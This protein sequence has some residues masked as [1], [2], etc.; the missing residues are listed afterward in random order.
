[1]PLFRPRTRVEILRDMIA[2]VVARSTLVGLR[3]NSVIFHLLAAAA[4]EDAEQYFQ[5]ANLRKLFSIYNATGSDLDERATEITPNTISRR[6]AQFASG[7][8]IFYRNGTVG[9]LTIPAGTLVAAEDAQG[10]IRFRTTATASITPG[11]D[12]VGGVGVVAVEAGARGSVA[13]NQIRQLVSRVVGLTGV[14]NPNRFDNGADR[15]SDAEFV[16]RLQLHVQSLSRGTVA[17]IRSFALNA[18]LND[19]RRALFAQVIEPAVP[20]CRFDVVI[21]DGTGTA[22]EYEAVFLG[23]DDVILNPA[24][25]GEVQV[26]TTNRPI[27]DDGSFL[28]KINGVTQTRGVDYELNA[29]RGIVELTAPLAPGDD[30]RARYRNYTGLIQEVQRVVD[31]DPGAPLVY[32]GVRAGGVLATVRAATAQWQTL[33]ASISVQ[34]DFDVETVSDEVKAEIARY[35]NGLDI[36]ADLIVAE[37]IERA[38][39]VSGMFNFQIVDLTGTFPAVDQVILPDQVAR[40]T[41]ADI[42]LT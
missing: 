25:G 40:I 22:E 18:Q 30:V 21:D 36:G 12:S 27:R 6:G 19:G 23:T 28:F 38:M 15:E 9:T 10:T 20:D 41:S 16:G 29:P 5:I 35:V 14:D 8:V 32:P 17:A 11:N 42:E 39:S 24:I 1:M 34:N 4:D 26:A 37:L 3:R 31:G 2:R 13:E 33:T 7:D